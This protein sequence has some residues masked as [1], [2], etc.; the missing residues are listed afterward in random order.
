M[1]DDVVVLGVGMTRFTKSPERSVEDLGHEAIL[2][3]MSDAG[4]Q[5]AD[6]GA[7]FFGTV[8]AHPGVG[9][10]VLKDLGMTGIPIVNLE[11]ACASGSTAV[12]DAFAWIR[13]DLVD[14]ALVVGVES[15]SAAPGLIDLGINDHMWGSGLVPPVYYAMMAKRHM[16]LYGTTLEQFAKVAVKSHAN[17]MLNPY[18]H[19][20]KPVTVEDVVSSPVVSDPITLYQCCPNVD[21]AAAAVLANASVARRFTTNPIKVVGSGLSSGRLQTQADAEPDLTKRTAR[22]AYEMAGIG[23]HDIDVAELHDA[24]AP[25]ELLYYEGLGFCG[26]GE[27]GSYIDQGRPAIGGDGVA[28][29]PSGG[30]LS[31]GHPFGAT[32]L[33]Q[34]AEL[35]W[36][37]RGCAG[38]RQVCEPKVALAHTVGG[39][40][41][42]LEANACAVHVLTR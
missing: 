33:A 10:R 4:V 3:A 27:G 15:L 29:N 28:V 38:D 39:T 13:A 35:A 20:H 32:G 37:L 25:G 1:M 11:N 19:F 23:P 42:E 14:A 41:F 22:L 16:A 18:A 12:R 24:F 8:Q 17:A 30:L 34:I 7:A 2:A 21:G 9:Q 5:R 36:Q 6:I 40:V 31:R 26:E